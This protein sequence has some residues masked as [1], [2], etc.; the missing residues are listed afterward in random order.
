M[1]LYRIKLLIWLIVPAALALAL[2]AAISR[3]AAAQANPA[4]MSVPAPELTGDGWLNTGKPLSLRGL[5]GQV[6]VLHFWTFGCINCRRNL[7]SYD[8]WQRRFGGRGVTVLGIHTPETEAER[9]PESVRREV[10]RLGITY[11][12]LTDERAENWRRWGQE[13]WPTVY[14]IDRRGRV[15][16][17][18]TGELEYQGAG[19]EARMGALVE[20]L[21]RE[22]A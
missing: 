22:R 4:R 20:G 10:E 13:Y 9:R 19:G 3:P 21:L 5:R 15:R 1:S 14:L 18:W 16:Y 8:R 2:A 7:P 6:V 12:V 17:R 11:P